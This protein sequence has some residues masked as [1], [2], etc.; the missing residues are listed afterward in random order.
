MTSDARCTVDTTCTFIPSKGGAKVWLCGETVLKKIESRPIQETNENK[1]VTKEQQMS[2]GVKQEHIVSKKLLKFCKSD[3]NKCASNIISISKPFRCIEENEDGVIM[4]LVGGDFDKLLNQ[5]VPYTDAPKILQQFLVEFLAV[6]EKLVTGLAFSHGDL[7]VKNLFYGIPPLVTDNNP[8]PVLA[9]LA[10]Q[11]NLPPVLAELA[12]QTSFPNIADLSKQQPYPIF[13]DFDKSSVIVDGK[14]FYPFLITKK[15]KQNTSEQT[16]LKENTNEE[17]SSRLPGLVKKAVKVGSVF[18]RK[19]TRFDGSLLHVNR[20]RHDPTFQ[21]DPT[22]DIYTFF[23][24]LFVNNNFKILMKKN[25]AVL[26]P[27]RRRILGVLWLSSSRTDEI[28]KYLETAQFD[29]PDSIKTAWKCISKFDYL[30]ASD[31]RTIKDLITSLA[32]AIFPS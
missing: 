12:P 3:S 25:P 32:T 18:K 27:M 29:D 4:P 24:S 17:K 11:N 23:V 30:R 8:P 15:R 6:I 1:T 13:A 5:L 28:I 16:K 2:Y 9:E 10:P 31:N 7:K 14:S 19:N 22:A 21:K 26:D 20:T